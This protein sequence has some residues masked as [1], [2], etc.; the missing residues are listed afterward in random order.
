MPRKLTSEDFI[1]SSIIR[2]G[3]HRSYIQEKILMDIFAVKGNLK[4]AE[5][6]RRYIQKN[7]A[8]L[9][10][11]PKI[12]LLDA[13]PAIGALTTL[14]ALREFHKFGLMDKVQVFLVDV[15]QRVIDKTQEGNFDFPKA[16]I[17]ASIRS[18]ILKKLKRSKGCVCSVSNLPFKDNYFDV[19]L[20]GFLFH[21]LHDDLKPLAAEQL[22]KVAKKNGFIGVAE[23][24]FSDYK[25]FYAKEHANDEIPLAYESIIPMAKLIKLFSSANIAEH[26]RARN[27]SKENYY[28]FCGEKK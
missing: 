19:V 7:L 21:H 16:L 23:E 25:R 13:G 17:D 28:Y 1:T 27:V 11:L 20:A 15:S 3:S 9:K 24:W 6:L 26:S 14:F 12:R 8:K 4:I 2:F 5:G 18:A 10:I 22:Q